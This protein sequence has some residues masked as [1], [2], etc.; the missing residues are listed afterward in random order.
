M[1]VDDL[2]EEM[3]CLRRVVALDSVESELID[4]KEIPLG[5]VLEGVGEALVGKGGPRP[6]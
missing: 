6:R 1:A 3:S 4:Q 5:V 2:V